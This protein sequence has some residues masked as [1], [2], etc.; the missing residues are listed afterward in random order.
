ML[1]REDRIEKTAKGFEVKSE[2][3]TKLLGGPYAT[4]EEALTRLQQVEYFKSNPQ[5]SDAAVVRFDSLG[6]IHVDASRKNE[7]FYCT[8]TPEGFLRCRGRLTR[9]NAVFQYQDSQGNEWGELRLEEDVFAP[10]AMESFSMAILTDDHP[11]GMVTLENVASVQKGHLGSEISREGLYL[12]ADILI[13][14]AD[15]I[16]RIEAGEKLE[17]S[18]GYFA[19]VI[20]FPGTYQGVPHAKKQT[21]FQGNHV[22]VVQE[23]RAGPECRLMLRADAAYQV[24]P[25]DKKDETMKIT[26]NGK[27]Q[28]VSPDQHKAL[29]EMFG[30][31]AVTVM[32]EESEDEDMG[33]RD[34]DMEMSAQMDALKAQNAALKAAADAKPSNLSFNS[35]AMDKRMALIDNARSICGADYSYAGKTDTAIKGAVIKAV[36]PSMNIDGKGA[37]YVDSAYEVALEAY[38]DQAGRAGSQFATQALFAGHTDSAKIDLD[39]AHADA[40]KQINDRARLSASQVAAQ[41]SAT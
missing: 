26:L 6:S 24:S 23:G 30:E 20:D 35:D 5:R 38:K 4:Y 12:V 41:W 15:L 10:D 16:R 19:D 31:D 8:K 1:V 33:A 25:P 3:G 21:N 14:D 39:R 18:C 11:A 2:D 32:A 27:E 29:I 34:E 13:T 37:V 40:N 22:A 17:L 7:G 36:L 9:A 28:E